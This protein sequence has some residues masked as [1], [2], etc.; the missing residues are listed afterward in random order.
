MK[1]VLTIVIGAALVV[2]ACTKTTSTPSTTA[3]GSVPATV[4][5]STLV[6][7]D[8]SVAEDSSTEAAAK[9]SV[10]FSKPSVSKSVIVPVI[11]RAV[12]SVI[13]QPGSSDDGFVGAASDATTEHCV[14]SADGWTADG[15]MTNT[16]GSNANYRVYVAFNAVGSTDTKALVQIN[17]AAKQGSRVAWSAKAVGVSGALECILRVERVAAK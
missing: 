14:K 7:G 8:G 4:A 1:R 9:S 5:A 16:S 12:T 11:K 6:V 15:K 2:G 3:A 13:V 17:V 10:A